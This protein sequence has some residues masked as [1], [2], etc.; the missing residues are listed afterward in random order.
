MSPADEA[1][2]TQE[3]K[4]GKAWRAAAP[5]ANFFGTTGTAI[6]D[7]DRST[8]E[9]FGDPDTPDLVLS[10]YILLIFQ[11]CLRREYTCYTQPIRSER[12]RLIVRPLQLVEHSP[13]HDSI[14]P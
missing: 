14:P 6:K 4:F 7:R 10:R 3:G 2:R 5:N 8:F 1:D 12:N 11:S 9:L 13:D